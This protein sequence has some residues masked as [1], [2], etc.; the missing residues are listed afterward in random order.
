[1]SYFQPIRNVTSKALQSSPAGEKPYEVCRRSDLSHKPAK[2]EI[3]QV[4]PNVPVSLPYRPASS[5]GS[6]PSNTI[7]A[8]G[9]EVVTFLL[10]AN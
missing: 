9:V 2:N 1:M 10:S 6:R 7:E 3:G 4:D 5:E 8:L